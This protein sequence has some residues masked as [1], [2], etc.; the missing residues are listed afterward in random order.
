M[1]QPLTI[2]GK[3]FEL[4][5]RQQPGG[6][7]HWLIAAPGKLVLSGEAASETLAREFA[8]SAGEALAR[9]AAA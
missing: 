3:T 9:L 8:H 4:T 1:I 2:E 5:L 7:W 6:D